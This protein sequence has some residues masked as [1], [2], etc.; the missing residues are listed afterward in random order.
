MHLWPPGHFSSGLLFAL[1]M[2]ETFSCSLM[3]PSA[4][5]TLMSPFSDAAMSASLSMSTRPG[6]TP[7]A[8]AMR[9]AARM[10]TLIVLTTN[11]WPKR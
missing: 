5:A 2:V 11:Y 8:A 9:R 3:A 10:V 7:L 1:M 4:L 6:R